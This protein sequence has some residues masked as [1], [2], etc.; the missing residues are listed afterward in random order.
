MNET[1]QMETLEPLPPRK[2]R[3]T[4]TPS[5]SHA[6][7]RTL[8][9]R[10]VSVF[11]G[12]RDLP[13]G[14]VLDLQDDGD[15]LTAILDQIRSDEGDERPAPWGETLVDVHPHQPRRFADEPDRFVPPGARHS[16]EQQRQAERP[17]LHPL[18]PEARLIPLPADA[19]ERMARITY[20]PPGATPEHYAAV[21][22]QVSGATGTGSRYQDPYAW[23]AG[24]HRTWAEPV[25][26]VARVTVAGRGLHRPALEAPPVTVRLAL[27]RG[28]TAEQVSSDEKERA[29]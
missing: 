5:R 15:D 20:P 28:G 22:C 25:L 21:M 1:P 10:F 9:S 4:L 3:H 16:R 14:P 8:R 19:V 11:R 17:R 24:T 23:G 29:A 13:D 7:P 12:H 26:D 2:P 27:P 18:P 6:K